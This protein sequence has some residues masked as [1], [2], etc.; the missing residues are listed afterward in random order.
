MQFGRT[1]VA[2]VAK[3]VD[4]KSEEEVEEYSGVFWKRYKELNDWERIIKNIE[5]G[6]GRIQRQQDIMRA[7]AS[8]LDRYR[9]PWQELKLQYG[10]NKGKAYTGASPTPLSAPATPRGI[11]VSSHCASRMDVA[12]NSCVIILDIGVLNHW[13]SCCMSSCHWG[14]MLSCLCRCQG[15]AV[16]CLGQ[17]NMAA[18]SF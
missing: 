13:Y 9:N 1:A 8:K 14:I 3:E 11:L 15:K 5:R 17:H 2:E 16:Q 6:E 4:G 7:I 18:T 12:L 10:A